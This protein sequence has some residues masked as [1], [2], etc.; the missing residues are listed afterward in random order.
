MTL[1]RPLGSS[2]DALREF[3][4]FKLKHRNLLNEM[5]NETRISGTLQHAAPDNAPSYIALSYAWGEGEHMDIDVSG[6][7]M[8]VGVNLYNALSSIRQASGHRDV[9]VWV[10]QICIN[11]NDQSEREHQVRHM[12]DIYAQATSVIAWVGLP[13]DGTQLL[14]AHLESIGL[15]HFRTSGNR[16][17]ATPDLVAFQD[18]IESLE[19]QSH[20][21]RRA[22]VHLASSVYWTR[23]WVIQE[24]AVAR[25]VIVACGTYRLSG[26]ILSDS[27]AEIGSTKNEL[28]GNGSLADQKNIDL[29]TRSYTHAAESF[30]QGV[31]S[32]R[33]RYMYMS[34]PRSLFSVLSTSSLLEEDY[35]HLSCSNPRD[36]IFAL[37]GLVADSDEF[38]FFPDYSSTCEKVYTLLAERFLQQGRINMLALCRAPRPSNLPSWVPDWQSPTFWPWTNDPPFDDNIYG[39]LSGPPIEGLKV[40]NQCGHLTLQ[41]ILVDRIK[42]TKGLWAPDWLSRVHPRQ[43]LEYLNGIRSLCRDSP[44]I[45]DDAVEKHSSQIAIAYRCIEHSREKVLEAYQTILQTWK[46]QHMPTKPPSDEVSWYVRVMTRLRPCRPTLSVSGFVGLAPEDVL[47]GDQVCLI[48]GASTP[49][50]VRQE[51]DG[52]YTLIGETY[53]DG[54]MYHDNYGGYL[55]RVDKYGGILRESDKRQTIT[56]K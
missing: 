26:D 14:F 56:L 2:K 5:F 6:R 32:L 44:R 34:T 8:S 18:V 23:V 1:Y 31:C 35:N 24:F 10:D 28:K 38:H 45:K 46:V 49:Y 25:D 37:L 7:N 54:L 17:T 47:E 22:F 11:Q 4:L 20:I 16:T 41:C 39:S 9:F 27:L 53:V 55:H 21:V 15:A 33:Q 13:I 36:R 50:I 12:R 30:M 51:N 40:D 3:R 42:T 52:L 43:G 48:S 19:G 29:I